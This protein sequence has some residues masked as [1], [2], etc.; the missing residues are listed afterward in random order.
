MFRPNGAPL[1][2]NWLHLPV[3]YHGRASSV[4]LSGTDVVRPRGQLQ[5]DREDPSQG[6]IFGP[7]RLMD[8]ELEMAFFVGG[9]PLAQGRGLTMAEAEDHIFGLVLMNDWSAR[10]I[11]KW[12]YVPLGPFGAKNFATSISPWVV[13]LDALEPYR[14]PTSAGEQSDP[15]PL[16][17]LRDPEYGSYDIALEVAIAN[18][19]EMAPGTAPATVCKSNFSNLYWNV[20]Q[21]LVHHAVTGCNMQPGDLLGSGTISGSSQD[22]FG[23]MLELCWKGTREVPLGDTINPST[24]APVVRK[25]LKDGDKVVMTGACGGKAGIGRV[26]FG[27]VEGTVL[28]ANTYDPAGPS[29]EGLEM[30]KNMPEQVD[31]KSMAEKDGEI[32]FSLKDKLAQLQE[33]ADAGFLTSAEF[34]AAK[35]RIISG[36]VEA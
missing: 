2:P 28:P 10:D 32:R 22:S 18:S 35:K 11:Q 4:Y 36:F 29:P 6:S 21:Q 30:V 16:E 1:L 8:F 15:V 9:P 17:Y 23:S 34:D 5:K 27:T 26:G 7:C 14:C 24:N 12:E 20:K 25:F 3:G 31:G 13:T 19:N 33:A